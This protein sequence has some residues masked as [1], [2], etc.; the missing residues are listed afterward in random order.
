MTKSPT[1]ITILMGL[2]LTG[3]AFAQT[4]LIPPPVNAGCPVVPSISAGFTP[5]I[6][7]SSRIRAFNPDPDGRVKSLYLSNGS[8]V[9]LSPDLGLAGS[10]LKKGERVSVSGARSSIL[11]QTVIAASSVTVGGQTFASR[12]GALMAGGTNMPPPP[13]RNANMPPPPPGD[14]EPG[15][16]PGGPELAM[17][18]PHGLDARE[19]G[20]QDEPGGD[21]ALSRPAPRGPGQEPPLPPHGN[22]AV[23]PPAASPRDK[24]QPAAQTP[25]PD[26]GPPASTSGA[27]SR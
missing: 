9:D 4:P 20:P 11:G 2:A 22:P 5:T 15:R 13:P 21:P 16:R 1:V 26:Q 8:V 10:S 6:T 24:G 18:G 14:N 27:V 17:R 12:P 3:A 19:P 25:A 23:A 7:Q